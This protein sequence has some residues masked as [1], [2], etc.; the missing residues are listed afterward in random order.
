MVL[1]FDLETVSLF[2]LFIKIY[3]TSQH[4]LLSAILVVYFVYLPHYTKEQELYLYDLVY[5]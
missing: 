2:I 3:G 1:I 5:C 4:L